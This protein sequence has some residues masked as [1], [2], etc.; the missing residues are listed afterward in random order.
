[1]GSAA[2]SAASDFVKFKCEVEVA[3]ALRDKIRK[4]KADSAHALQTLEKPQME[5]VV[6]RVH[7]HAHRPTHSRTQATR[8][9]THSRRT[10]PHNRAPAPATSPC[11]LD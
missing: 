10:T 11:T 3:V 5:Q 1:M 4:I 6:A 8:A 7:M 2:I 9:R